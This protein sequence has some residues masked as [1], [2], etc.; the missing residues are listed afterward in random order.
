MYFYNS[1]F[2]QGNLLACLYLNI[3]LGY[4]YITTNNSVCVC[5]IMIYRNIFGSLDRIGLFGGLSRMQI[6]SRMINVPITT[7]NENFKL[8]LKMDLVKNQL[9]RCQ[10]HLFPFVHSAKLFISRIFSTCELSCPS[11]IPR[12]FPNFD[13]CGHKLQGLNLNFKLL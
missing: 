4:N 5:T 1:T 6:F 7:R 10:I 3:Y 9:F 11:Y 12:E 13:N 2:F 8:M